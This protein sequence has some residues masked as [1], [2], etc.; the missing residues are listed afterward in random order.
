[1]TSRMTTRVRAF[2]LVL[3]MGG[4]AA[5]AIAACSL[6]DNGPGATEG[7][8]GLD[9]PPPSHIDLRAPTSPERCTLPSGRPSRR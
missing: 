9:V 4:G 7:E 1:M 3:G 5:S 2:L 6:G 8:A